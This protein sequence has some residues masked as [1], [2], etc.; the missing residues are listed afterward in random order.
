MKLFYLVF[1]YRYELNNRRHLLQN[2]AFALYGS[3]SS[4]GD[5]FIN[6]IENTN[7]EGY[8]SRQKEN[9]MKIYDKICEQSKIYFFLFECL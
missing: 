9:V 6:N 5:M 2:V 8:T 4:E 3:P 7:L 1:F